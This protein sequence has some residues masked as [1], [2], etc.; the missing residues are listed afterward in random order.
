[1]N[2]EAVSKSG[3][4][5]AA[6]PNVLMSS[7]SSNTDQWISMWTIQSGGS[8]WLWAVLAPLKLQGLPLHSVRFWMLFSFHLCQQ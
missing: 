4:A 8:Q 5:T 1:M 3:I 7:L 2:F 6:A